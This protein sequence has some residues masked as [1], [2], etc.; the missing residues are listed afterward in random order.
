MGVVDA[1]TVLAAEV[2]RRSYLES[3]VFG[4]LTLIIRAHLTYQHRTHFLFVPKLE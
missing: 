4:I 1:R 3:L 2:Y